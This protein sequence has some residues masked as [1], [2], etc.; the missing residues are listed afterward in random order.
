M[1][2]T[3]GISWTERTWNPVTGC[4]KVSTGCDNC[5][6]LTLAPRLKAMG[7]KRYEKDGDPRTSG[8]GFGVTIHPDLVD[9]PRH[10][11]KPSM[12]FV[13]SMSDLLH[14]KVP[15]EFTDKVFATMNETP[16]TFQVLTKRSTRLKRVADRFEW[17]PN[18]W[19]GVSVENEDAMYRIDDLKQT[20]AAV[21]FLSCEPLLGPLP[22]LAGMLDGIDWVIVGG[23]SGPNYRPLDLGWAREVRDV[24]ADTGTAFFFKQVG[25]IKSKSGGNLL[26]GKVYEEMP[27]LAL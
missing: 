26:D 10:W 5:Y 9:S 3:T 2:K 14:A 19:M 20:P 25:G 12:V 13:N 22:G 23:E 7:S 15:L 6:A 16:H 17:T 11:R 24:C 4:D 27:A 18:I 1:G 8:P 21:K